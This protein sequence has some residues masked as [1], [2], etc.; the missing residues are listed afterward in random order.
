MIGVL[1]QENCSLEPIH[2]VDSVL[3]YNTYLLQLLD[4]EFSLENEVFFAV[5][6]GRK[7]DLFVAAI[8]G[9]CFCLGRA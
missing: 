1:F 5:F 7:F 8:S 4:S 2:V 9:L 6:S 3:L